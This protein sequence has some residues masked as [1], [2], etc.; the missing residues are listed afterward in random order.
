MRSLCLRAST[1][2]LK[3]TCPDARTK[4]PAR[5]TL[6]PLWTTDLACTS[7]P[8][9]CAEV[10][11]LRL[12]LTALPCVQATKSTDASTSMRATTTLKP[13]SATDLVWARPTTSAT[14]PAP[15]LTR[16]TTACATKMKSQAA[17]TVWRALQRRRHHDDGSCDT[18]H[19]QEHSHS[20]SNRSCPTR[21]FDDLPR[22]R[23]HP[24]R[25]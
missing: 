2:S 12:P 22:V 9:A 15:F 14:A 6:K 8:S 7:T 5:S 1:S 23:E 3:K 17:P 24:Q 11:A 25:F 10:I 16:T 13:T 19:A 20:R 18:A 21:R 4:R